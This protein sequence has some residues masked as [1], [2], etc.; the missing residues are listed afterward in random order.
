[1]SLDENGDFLINSRHTWAAYRLDRHTGE[2]KWRLGGKKSDFALGPNVA[3]AWQHNATAVDHHGLIRFFDNEASP[4]V[5]PYSRVI[6]VRHDDV[7][8]TATLERWFK[9]P[10]RAVRRVA[11]ERSGAG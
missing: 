8:K 7:N 6:W 11:G 10:R 2:V 1:M 5:L 9:H 4:T 3:F